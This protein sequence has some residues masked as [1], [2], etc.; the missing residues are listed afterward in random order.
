MFLRR[1]SL[2][3]FIYFTGH[4]Q[5]T[6]WTGF[7]RHRNNNII[8]RYCIENNKNLF[9]FGDMDAY[10]FNPETSEWEYSTYTYS[11][12][13]VP[14]EHPHYL[15]D[16]EYEWGHT[17]YDNCLNKGGAWWWMMARLC[18]WSGPMEIEE[19]QTDSYEESVSVYPNP[20]NSALNLLSLP[21]CRYSVYEPSG[22]LV[23]SGVF[24]SEGFVSLSFDKSFGSGLYLIRFEGDGYVFV[25]KAVLI[26]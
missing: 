12:N 26:R 13:I 25:K 9:D 5:Y 19:K 18:G 8:R 24:D 20:F 22:R 15:E 6:D 17:G 10:W 7:N 2:S 3:K 16:G 21:D 11:G 4:A 14:R 1:V 23:G